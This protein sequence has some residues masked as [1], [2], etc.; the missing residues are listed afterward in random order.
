MLNF[1]WHSAISRTLL[2]CL[3]DCFASLA[4]TTED[5]LKDWV[6][7]HPILQSQNS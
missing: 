6:L 4:V 7:T 5:R 1:R 3:V 2:D